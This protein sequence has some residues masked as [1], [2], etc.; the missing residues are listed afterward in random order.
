MGS[1]ILTNLQRTSNSQKIANAKIAKMKLILLLIIPCLVTS[2]GGSD[3]NRPGG[4]DFNP[5]SRNPG[6]SDFNPGS[7][8]PGGSDTNRPGGSDFNSGSRNPGGSDFNP[9]HWSNFGESNRGGS[10]RF[11]RWRSHY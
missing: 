9:G 8:N 5:G 2:Q 11:R 3:T 10:S 6:G 4:S 1:L 7:R